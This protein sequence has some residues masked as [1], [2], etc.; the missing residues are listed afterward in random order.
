MSVLLNIIV[1]TFVVS[2]I[3]FAGAFS[4]F[5]KEK[6]ISRILL[7]F[8]T[9]SA[10]A[11]MGAAFLDLLPEAIE[12]AGLSENNIFNTFIYLLF[13]FCVFFVLEQFIKWHHHHSLHH[14][15]IA[16]FSYLILVSDGL[17][18]FMDGLIIAASFSANFHLGIV[19]TFAVMAHEIPQEI[20]DFS[21]LIYG[22]FKKKTALVINFLSGMIAIIGG[23]IG[24]FLTEFLSGT[25]GLLAFAAGNFLYIS[26]SD[27]IPEI[28]E[29]TGGIKSLV[30]FLVF[31]A[32]I[33]FIA[34]LK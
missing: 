5:F 14:P 8:V 21:V 31:L 7:F 32:G 17:H 2:L 27:L 30:H 18:N 22:G 11:L 29:E 20:G 6:I 4:L 3:S 10:G 23:I 15:H 24:F 25:Y 12:L 13:G 19:S 16:P 26:A 34:I 28:K 1:A 9:F 33:A